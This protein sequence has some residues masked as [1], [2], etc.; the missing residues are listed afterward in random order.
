MPRGRPKN[1]ENEEEYTEQDKI[2]AEFL[3]E[4]CNVPGCMLRFH[5]K[6]AKFLSNYLQSKNYKI[7]K[8]FK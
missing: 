5:L 2:I 6:D 1:I 4:K 8:E 3:A 7:S